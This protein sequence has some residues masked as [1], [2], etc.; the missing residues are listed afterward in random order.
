MDLHPEWE[1]PF[2][3]VGQVAQLTCRS[4]WSIWEAIKEGR[5]KANKPGGVGDYLIALP[6]LKEWLRIPV[7]QTEQ[8]DVAATG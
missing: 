7:E 5:L 2:Y 1:K 8:D 4:K 6:D 3:N